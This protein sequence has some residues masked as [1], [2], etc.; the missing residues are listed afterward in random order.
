MRAEELL[1]SK[2][3]ESHRD[4]CSVIAHVQN[5]SRGVQREWVLLKQGLHL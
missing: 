1:F 3:C 5:Q 4:D 2:R